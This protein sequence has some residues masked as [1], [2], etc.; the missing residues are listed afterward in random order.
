MRQ[1]T[2]IYKVNCLMGFIQT[3]T[4]FQAEEKKQVLNI[5]KESRRQIFEIA[6]QAFEELCDLVLAHPVLWVIYKNE[7]LLAT[8]LHEIMSQVES[9]INSI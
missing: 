8:H 6:N 7:H 5:T 3:E 1:E 4:Y 9:T 2:F